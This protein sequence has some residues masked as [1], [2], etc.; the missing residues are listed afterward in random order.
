MDVTVLEKSPQ[1]FLDSFEDILIKKE[2]VTQ[3]VGQ[4]TSIQNVQK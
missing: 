3:T 4:H 2:S 1:R